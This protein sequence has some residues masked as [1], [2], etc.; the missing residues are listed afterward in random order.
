M[1]FLNG[2]KVTDAVIGSGKLAMRGSNVTIRYTAN[3]NHGKAFQTDIEITSEV[4]T[5]PPQFDCEKRSSH[6]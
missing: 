1:K 4:G 5:S 2:L 3:L 6:R